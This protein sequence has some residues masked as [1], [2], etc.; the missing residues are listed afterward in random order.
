MKLFSGLHLSIGH[1][2]LCVAA[3]IAGVSVAVGQNG[4]PTSG[5]AAVAPVSDPVIAAQFEETCAGC[6]GSGGRSGDR[7]PALANSAKLR[8]MSDAGIAAIIRNGA[9]GMPAFGFDDKQLAS[10][11][12]L[13][14]SWNV[15]AAVTATDAQVAA[16]EA[17]F[18]GKGQCADCHMVRGRGGSNG[19]DLTFIGA[20]S[21]PDD[22]GR[23]LDN[24]TALM[25]SRTTASCPGW[26]FCPD[27]QWTIVNVRMRDGTTLRGFARNEAENSLQLQTLDG[28]LRSIEAG[29][30]IDYSRETTSYMP[31]LKASAEERRDVIA[32][33]ASLKTQRLGPVTD[34]TVP[35]PTAADKA[36]VLT[37]VRGEWPSYNG[38]PS[39]NRHSALAQITSRNVDRLRLSWMFSPGGVGLETTPVVVDGVMYVTGA[40]Q[41]CALDARNGRSFWCAGRT[42]RQPVPAGGIAETPRAAPAGVALQPVGPATAARPS[43]GVASGN[44][45]NRGVAVVGDRVIFTSDDAYLI[46]INRLTGGVMWTVPLTDP[47]YGGRYYATP[48]PLVIGDLVVSGVSGG[49]SPTRGFLA[50]FDVTT[51]KLA[52]RFWTVP[53]PGDPAAATWQ[54]PDMATG[55]AA[56]WMTGSYDKDSNTVFWGVG[57]P[58]PSTDG[59]GRLG[60]NLYANSVIALDGATGKLRWHYQFTP[61]D[62]HDWDATAPMVLVDDVYQGKRRK[63]LMQANRNGFFYVLD[64]TNGQF[65][66]AKPFVEKMNWASGIDASGR[67]I[68]VPGREPNAEG[69]FACP[70]VRGATN[71]YSTAYN[72]DTRLF[73]V[74]AAEDCGIFRTRGRIYGAN[75]DVKNPGRRYVR[76]LNPETGAIVWEKALT[77]SHEANYSGVL[78]TAGGLLFHGETAGGF[79][80][81]DA[82]TGK[83]LW[84]VP[85]N[86][87]WRA[88]PMTY[89]V[90]DRQYVAVAAGSNILSFALP[91]QD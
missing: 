19:P 71:W 52:W 13:I 25:G 43:A 16:G 78:S 21:T 67:P 28:R 40:K 38:L 44:G 36:A 79:A 81:V 24:P 50:A 54:G 90:K 66:F 29:E 1:I 57:N 84:T 9:G 51:G 12:A 30:Y 6:H 42:A 23:M 88:S 2:M 75:V 58:Y 35:P 76:A 17:F 65:L 61:H 56:T 82:K 69:V 55:G 41:V 68:L 8:A 91:A 15:V 31:A 10:Y 72:P 32:Y 87:A 48:A 26:A 80:A 70:A 33:M 11:V 73:Y 64:R 59:S 62:V 83:T 27:M 77:G 46:C 85:T 47:A 18:F 20:T 74:M 37:P 22:M 34:A 45:P 89:M 7:A 39:G 53:A 63:L 14:R 3:A 86:D 5:A 4:T 60:D 49:D